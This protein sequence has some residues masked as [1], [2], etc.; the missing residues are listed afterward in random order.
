MH[1]AFARHTRTCLQKKKK[2]F[3][4]PD[5]KITSPPR[6][7]FHRTMKKRVDRN[8]TCRYLHSNQRLIAL[9]VVPDNTSTNA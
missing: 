3:Y 7:L 2:R 8:T 9:Q 4:I 6:Q 5:K 1:F